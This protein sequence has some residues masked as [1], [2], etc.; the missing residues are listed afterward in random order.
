MAPAAGQPPG[1][2][3]TCPGASSG[4]SPACAVPVRHKLLARTAGELLDLVTVAGLAAG[5]G[6][7]LAGHDR[8]LIT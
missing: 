7:R 4:S 3:G 8:R 1:P 6:E 5:L 2:A